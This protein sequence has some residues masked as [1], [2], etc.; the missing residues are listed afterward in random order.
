VRGRTLTTREKIGLM[1]GARSS[2]RVRGR[3]FPLFRQ[4]LI[5]LIFTVGSYHT[6]AMLMRSFGLALDDDLRSFLT[7]ENPS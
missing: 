7:T 1:L 3:R 6:L 5:D 4:Q 2:A